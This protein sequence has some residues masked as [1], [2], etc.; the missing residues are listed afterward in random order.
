MLEFEFD[1]VVIFLQPLV[2]LFIYLDKFL[3]GNSD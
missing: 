2:P 1:V 3:E